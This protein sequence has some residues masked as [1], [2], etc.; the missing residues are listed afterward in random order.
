LLEL[1]RMLRNAELTREYCGNLR[2][3]SRQGLSAGIAADF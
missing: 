1:D 2:V 3:P